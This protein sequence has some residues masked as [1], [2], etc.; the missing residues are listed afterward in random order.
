MTKRDDFGEERKKI[1]PPPEE[2]KHNVDRFLKK[3]NQVEF[4]GWLILNNA[5]HRE[6]LNLE[7]HIVSG[8]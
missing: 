4:E 1:T 7:K 5:S 6:F 2:I 3:W 8:K